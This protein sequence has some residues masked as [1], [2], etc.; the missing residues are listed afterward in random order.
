MLV[1][2]KGTVLFLVFFTVLGSLSSLAVELESEVSLSAYSVELSLVAL[3]ILDFE[4]FA[5]T[6]SSTL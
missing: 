1:N 6:L 3:R 2:G 4:A 5:G